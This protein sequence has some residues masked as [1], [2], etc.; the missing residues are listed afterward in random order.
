MTIVKQ[1]VE[2]P[3]PIYIGYKEAKPGQVLVSGTFVGTKMVKPYQPIKADG[4]PAEDVPSHV[5]DTDTGDTRLNSATNLNRLLE[6]IEPG[7][8]LE[9]IYLGRTA[10]TSK[11][12][13]KYKQIDFEVNIL[14]D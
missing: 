7:T 6:L 3:K 10:K 2:L 13:M 12:G 1:K 14:G 4:T 8:P 11:D 9:V 5:F